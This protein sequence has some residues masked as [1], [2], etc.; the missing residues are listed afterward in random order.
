MLESKY[1]GNIKE[2]TFLIHNLKIIALHS[3]AS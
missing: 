3:G 1:Y 2:P